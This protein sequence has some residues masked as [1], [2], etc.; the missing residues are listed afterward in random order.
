MKYIITKTDIYLK[1]KIHPEGSV[2]DSSKYTEEEIESIKHLLIPVEKSMNVAITLDNE[3]EN[4][5][6]AEDPKPKRPRN[7]KNK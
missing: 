1:G 5:V 3:E 2:I 7:P 6:A 4:Q